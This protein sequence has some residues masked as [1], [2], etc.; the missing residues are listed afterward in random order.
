MMQFL[1]M[2]LRQ[3]N[4]K[5]TIMAAHLPQFDRQEFKPARSQPDNLH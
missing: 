4:K 1:V 3:A 5:A 2:S